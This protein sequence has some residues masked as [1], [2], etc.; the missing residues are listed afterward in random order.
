VATRGRH[1]LGQADSLS[2]LN[3]MID[4]RID[5]ADQEKMGAKDLV[6]WSSARVGDGLHPGWPSI[7]DRD[8]PVQKAQFQVLQGSVEPRNHAGLL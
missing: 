4:I 5:A 7:G 8:R 6:Y 2:L 3:E 1:A